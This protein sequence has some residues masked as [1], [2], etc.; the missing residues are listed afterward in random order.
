[1]P[2]RASASASSGTRSRRR[3]V[4]T[5][6]IGKAKALSRLLRTC[7][8]GDL[9]GRKV[10]EAE[11]Q[12]PGA[13]AEST[14]DVRPVLRVV[15]VGARVGIDEAVLQ[16]A[17]DQNRE[18]AC[19]GGDR[20]GLPDAERDSSVERAERGL[21]APQVHGSESEDGRRPVGGR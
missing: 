7:S 4:S 14:E 9:A 15:R 2:M 10:D 16:G 18:L 11:S 5:E 17:I 19:G 1:M 8:L 6:L 20:L 21:R 13:L 12:I 3:A